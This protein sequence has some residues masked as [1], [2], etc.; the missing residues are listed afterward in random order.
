MTA[1]PEQASADYIC[2]A[3]KLEATGNFRV[4]RRA[5]EFPPMPDDMTGLRRGIIVDVETTGLDP[6]ADAIIQLAIL[7]FAYDGQGRVVGAGKPF[8]G[9]EDPVLP[10]P[11]KIAQLTGLTDDMLMGQRI[12]DADV[13]AAV[14]EPEIVIAHNA[15]FD[16][17]FLERR[18]PFFQHLPFGCSMTDVPW[19]EEGFEGAKLAYLMMGAGLFHDAHDAAG[20]CFATLT[21][22]ALALPRAGGTALSAVLKAAADPGYRFWAV[23]AAIGLKDVLKARGYR[24]NPGDDGHPRSWY[25]D[26]SADDVPAEQKFLAEEIYRS[27]F[28]GPV[29]TAIDPLNRFSSRGL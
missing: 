16:R 6:K 11:S 13:M 25:K 18:F 17:K 24:W 1:N 8:V 28:A 4:L 2:M 22:L 20:D 23:G 9:L 3:E 19:E 29:I 5:P 26:V 7:P 12:D 21:L 14:G 27:D 15:S 10:I